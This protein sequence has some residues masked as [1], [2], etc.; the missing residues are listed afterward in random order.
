MES[1]NNFLYF[2]FDY[3]VLT[4]IVIF[5]ILI[6]T[7]I[8]N[9]NFNFFKNSNNNLQSN[10]EP[11]KIINIETMENKNNKHKEFTKSF[12][13]NYE[14]DHEILND[15]TKDFSFENC[16]ST[17]CSVWVKNKDGEKCYGGDSNGPYLKGTLENPLEIDNFFYKNECIS[18]LKKCK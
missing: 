16:N 9:I 10:N 17:R 5:T 18:G 12:C 1:I 15:K 2:N 4:V 13:D 8:L 14:N 7:S 3:I 6:I 11:N